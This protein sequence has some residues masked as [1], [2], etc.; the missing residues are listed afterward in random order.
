MRFPEVKKSR[1]NL[2]ATPPLTLNS[3]YREGRISPALT[4]EEGAAGAPQNV[5]KVF[6]A[7]GIGRFFALTADGVYISRDGISYNKFMDFNVVSPFMVEE[8]DG[9]PRAEIIIGDIAIIY[10]KNSYYTTTYGA[11]LSAGIMHCG[12][13]FGADADNGFI[14]RW[15][16][17]GGVTDW[18]IKLYGAGYLELD[19]ERGKILDI[20]EMDGYMILVREYGLTKLKMYGTPENFSQY[21]T[22][23]ITGRIVKDTA[24]V[25]GGK[26]YF[27][28]TAGLRVY[29]GNNIEAIYHPFEGDIFA[30]RASLSHDGKY[31]LSCESKTFGR[32]IFC[33][34]D[35]AAYFIGG[36]CEGMCI[37]EKV[38]V[39]AG[40]K[41]GYLSLGESVK[42]VYK[43]VNF[44][45]LKNKTLTSIGTF[46]SDARVT[47]KS[48]TAARSLSG[49]AV[50][51]RMR[52]KV[53]DITFESGGEISLITAE[54]EVSV[55]I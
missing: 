27:M 15:S 19:K 43:N 24:A 4:P 48:K 7:N 45:T 33:Y 37:S 52:G 10:N 40:G 3:V 26:L 39:V 42:A 16:G 20:L 49:R 50:R 22:G 12:R 55:G 44:G 29:D 21:N 25:V 31:L 14:L 8:Y 41:S 54:A 28:T 53:F 36:A 18:E 17:E 9:E 35:G 2:L 13:L 38:Y 30:P 11:K 32:G 23:Y 34:D 6:K 51:P 1:I 46:A 47:V 5:L